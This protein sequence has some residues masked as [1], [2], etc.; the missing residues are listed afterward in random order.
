[1]DAT[2]VNLSPVM[3]AIV[4]LAQILL[5]SIVTGIITARKER[6]DSERISEAAKLAAKIKSDEKQE[7]WARQDE[8]AKRVE[9]AA[10]Q[11]AA[12]AKL[13]L[14]SQEAT[15]AATKEVARLA[16][17]SD[18]KVM[19]GLAMI[20]QGNEKIHILVNSDMTAARTAERDA[21]KLTLIALKRVQV[22]SEKLGLQF[23]KD[24][25]DDITGFEKRI[26]ELDHILA[27][28]LAAQRR[29]DEGA[30]EKHG[31]TIGKRATDL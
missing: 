20:Q 26:I 12:A 25:K 14:A 13:L 8:V 19:E 30:A 7:D 17:E 21:V 22:M 3:L 9:E 1:V 16:A 2:S 11:A 10:T 23:T 18:V 29:L 27:D 5:L 24:E 15:V 6:R 28:R 4:A 31:T